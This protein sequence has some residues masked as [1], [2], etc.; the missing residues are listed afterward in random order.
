VT[1]CLD[2]AMGFELG[3]PT[4][5]ND[6]GCDRPLPAPAINLGQKATIS[7]VNELD[8]FGALIVS[9]IAKIQ[10]PISVRLFR[11][12]TTE[13]PVEAQEYGSV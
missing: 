2:K 10:S 13:K 12:Q 6:I 1:Y 11:R 4:T 5:I 3:R 9:G 8:S 7:S